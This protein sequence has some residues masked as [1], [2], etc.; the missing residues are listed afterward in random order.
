METAV[1]MDV[2]GMEDPPT[3]QYPLGDHDFRQAQ[4]GLHGLHSD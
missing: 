4:I 1:S 2:N 3:S